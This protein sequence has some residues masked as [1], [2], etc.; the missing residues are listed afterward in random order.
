MFEVIDVFCFNFTMPVFFNFIGELNALAIVLILIMLIYYVFEV[1]IILASIF[2][3]HVQS[4]IDVS[5]P[6]IQELFFC[7]IDDVIFFSGL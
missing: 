3:K 5:D 2:L 6:F 1:G 7:F 4:I